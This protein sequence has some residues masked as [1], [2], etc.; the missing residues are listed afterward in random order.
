MVDQN[1][2]EVVAMQSHSEDVKYQYLIQRCATSLVFITLLLVVL[3]APTGIAL[4]SDPITNEAMN[5]HLHKFA[6]HGLIVI[7]VSQVIILF[8]GRKFHIAK[9]PAHA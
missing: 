8:L 2:T 6:G 9:P 3:A 5:G 4:S 1:M 7:A